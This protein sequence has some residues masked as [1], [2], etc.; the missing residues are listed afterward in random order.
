MSTGSIAQDLICLVASLLTHCL[1][2]CLPVFL[3]IA[4]CVVHSVHLFCFRM[5]STSLYWPASACLH[6]NYCFFTSFFG[7]SSVPFFFMP[8]LLRSFTSLS[9]LCCCTCLLSASVFL[10]AFW[11]VLSSVV[12]ILLLFSPYFLFVVLSLLFCL[13]ACVLLHPCF[14][15][16]D[17]S[18]SSWNL[19]AVFLWV[20]SHYIFLWLRLASYESGFPWLFRSFCLLFFVSVFLPFLLRFLCYWVPLRVRQH[21]C[22]SFLY[23]LTS[24]RACEEVSCGS[25]NWIPECQRSVQLF[26]AYCLQELSDLQ[27]ERIMGW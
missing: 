6:L 13:L 15:L 22:R 3:S 21:L 18:R 1:L 23:S 14:C 24:N 8:F 19:R 27:L 12:F 16:K 2:L 11:Y 10:L 9:N 17:W 25:S 20:R 26:E 4:Y 7:W 5:I